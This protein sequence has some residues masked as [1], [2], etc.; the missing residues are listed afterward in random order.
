MQ[1]Y[2]PITILPGIALIILSTTNLWVSLSEEIERLENDYIEEKKEVINRKIRQLSLLNVSMMLQYFSALLMVF[3]GMVS[4][5]IKI[6]STEAIAE[7]WMIWLTVVSVV[8]L[9]ISL[10]VLVNYSYKALSIRKEQ[11]RIVSK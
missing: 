9:V 6:I 11:F 10:V 7:K 2:L 1:W 8:S 5:W 3:A 4:G